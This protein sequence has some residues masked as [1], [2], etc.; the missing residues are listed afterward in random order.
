MRKYL[1]DN[2]HTVWEDWLGEIAFGLR[3]MVSWAHGFSPFMLAF[4][5]SPLLPTRLSH[6]AEPEEWLV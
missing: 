2:P 1:L 6:L 4:K 3:T 5:Q